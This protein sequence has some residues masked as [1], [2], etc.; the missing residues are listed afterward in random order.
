M[1]P[2]AGF[3]CNLWMVIFYLSAKNTNFSFFFLPLQFLERHAAQCSAL[4]LCYLPNAAGYTNW[5]SRMFCNLWPWAKAAIS[6]H[7]HMSSR[8]FTSLIMGGMGATEHS[9]L[10]LRSHGESRST[11]DR[12]KLSSCSAS[13]HQLLPD[14]L[15]WLWNPQL[16]RTSPQHCAHHQ[17]QNPCCCCETQGAIAATCLE[18][19]S[20]NWQRG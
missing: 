10:W 11:S 1:Q 17:S 19:N 18:T 3:R 13:H 15:P 7:C 5:R 8:E 2:L 16:C 4:L 6:F 14:G 20:C 9:S 12:C